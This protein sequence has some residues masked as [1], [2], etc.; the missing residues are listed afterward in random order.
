M[1]IGR[2]RSFELAQGT[3]KYFKHRDGGV[4]LEGSVSLTD[5][6]ATKLPS[7]LGV[8]VTVCI[9]RSFR[10][11]LIISRCVAD[12]VQ[13]SV[14]GRAQDIELVAAT[15]AEQGKWMKGIQRE[16]ARANKHHNPVDA[17]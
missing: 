10:N 11:R 3:I 15:E 9:I 5:A 6:R 17:L 2:C 1:L 7:G 16:I 4:E 13:V 8:M 14:G 12:V